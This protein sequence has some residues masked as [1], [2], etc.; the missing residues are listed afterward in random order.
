[1][2]DSVSRLRGLA[3]ALT[4][5][6]AAAAAGCGT[7]DDGAAPVAPVTVTETVTELPS[8]SPSGSPS[9]TVTPSEGATFEE[10]ESA[11]PVPPSDQPVDLSQPPQTY[12]EA[13][14]H[15]AAATGG[16]QEVKRF[17]SPDGQ[18]YCVFADRYVPPSCEVLDGVSDPAACD[19]SPSQKVGRIELTGRGWTAFCNTDT[20]RMPGAPKVPVGAVASWPARGLECVL[21][22]PGVT[23]LATVERLGFFFG[24]GRYEI[25]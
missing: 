21:E 12:E 14:A 15:V 8:E 3:L 9:Q 13:E 16:R 25:F 24:S 19:G 23:C 7:A 10:S 6:A 5:A 18:F 20:V 2:T 4:L 11:T 22:E 1:M 17:E